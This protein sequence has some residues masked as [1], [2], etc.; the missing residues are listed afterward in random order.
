MSLTRAQF[1]SACKAYIEKY[2]A[3]HEHGTDEALLKRYPTGWSWIE[4]T[5]V[6]GLGYLSRKVSI[7]S[8]IQGFLGEDQEGLEAE[9]VDQLEEDSAEASQSTEALTCHQHVVYSPSFQVPALYFSVH[10]SSGAPLSLEELTA[11]SLLRLN[12]LPST[13]ATT[14]ALQGPDAAFTLL[15]QGDHPTLG[16]PCWYLHPCHTGEVI[17]EILAEVPCEG[18][19]RSLRWLEAWFM[20]LGNVVDF[21]DT[22]R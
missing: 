5:S 14:Y 13:Q 1:E 16:T 20:M 12:T 9:N 15:S 2:S 7:L 17:E 18:N 19:A 22:R 3:R 4:H 21:G 10:Q 8:R 6:A 11:C